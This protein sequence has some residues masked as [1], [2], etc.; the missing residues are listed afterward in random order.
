MPL[1]LKTTLEL[2]R[3]E[4]LAEDLGPILDELREDYEKIAAKGH[5]YAQ[6]TTEAFLGTERFQFKSVDNPLMLARAAAADMH[7]IDRV[8]RCWIHLRDRVPNGAISS[9]PQAGDMWTTAY[10]MDITEWADRPIEYAPVLKAMHDRLDW[11]AGQKLEP[12]QGATSQPS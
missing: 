6:A 1:A 4:T 10:A 7:A 9:L 8:L 3:D 5:R 11:L 2:L 12:T